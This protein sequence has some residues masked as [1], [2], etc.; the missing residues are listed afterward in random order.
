MRKWRKTS[1]E[2]FWTVRC[3]RAPLEFTNNWNNFAG[4]DWPEQ[5]RG[6]FKTELEACVWARDN[7]LPGAPFNLLFVPRFAEE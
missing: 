2:A 5:V 6:N 4:C 3:F 1:V 7:L